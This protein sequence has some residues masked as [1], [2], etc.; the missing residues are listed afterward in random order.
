MF[1]PDWENLVGKQLAYI[2]IP[3]TAS[4]SAIEMFRI[5]SLRVRYSSEHRRFDDLVGDWDW[6]GIPDDTA[7]PDHDMA[8]IAVVR[9]PYDWITSFYEHH[10]RGRVAGERRG[11]HQIGKWASFEEFVYLI[12]DTSTI[13]F[14]QPYN[15]IH[16]QIYSGN[17]C[18]PQ[19]LI[20]YEKVNEGWQKIL[21]KF[22]LAPAG[23]VKLSR[24]NT[25]RHHLS[26]YRKYYDDKS[27][28]KM[29]ARWGNELL[30]LGYTIDGPIDDSIFIDPERCHRN[31]RA[32]IKC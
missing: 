30:S 16:E 28:E 11:P 32:L 8:W 6:S 10:S 26:E 23:E 12:C 29:E 17:K 19:I 4:T 2:R 14:M 1:E 7:P 13:D 5:N 15:W 9:N 22:D 3:K 31:L 27:I 25:N 24:V 18:M 20:R 21:D